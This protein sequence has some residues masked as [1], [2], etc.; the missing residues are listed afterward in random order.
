MQNLGSAGVAR[1]APLGDGDMRFFERCFLDSSTGP[2]LPGG[3]NP[4][5]NTS[6]SVARRKTQ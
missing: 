3:R 5:Q 4:Y 1:R 2:N 6:T